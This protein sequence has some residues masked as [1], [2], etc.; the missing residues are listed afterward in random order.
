ME[1]F[2]D[3]TFLKRSKYYIFLFGVFL[4]LNSVKAL[5]SENNF[6]SRRNQKTYDFEQVYF[7]NSIPFSEH[8]GVDGQ[9][10]TFFGLKNDLSRNY[11]QD[12]TLIND[13]YDLREIY[14][15]KLND[16]IMDVN[17]NKLKK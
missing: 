11:Y 1:F 8:D 10:K 6:H 3:I 9:L 12:L 2:T 5:A 13:S 14:K 7:Q 17:N 15:L 4:F 16:M